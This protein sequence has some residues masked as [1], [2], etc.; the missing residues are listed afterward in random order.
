MKMEFLRRKSCTKVV[1]SVA[2]FGLGRFGWE[3][4]V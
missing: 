4:L 3:G 1:K 2:E